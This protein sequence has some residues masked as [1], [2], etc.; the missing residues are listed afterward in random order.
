MK[1][2]FDPATGKPLHTLRE[3]KLNMA[4]RQDWIE[5]PDTFDTRAMLDFTVIGGALVE[6]GADG[7]RTWA[8][9]AVDQ[10]AGRKRL[11]FITDSPGQQA[12]YLAKEAEARAYVA[13]VSPPA[14]LADYP[15]IASEIG[16]TGA[17]ALEVANVW[18]A[19]ADQW[20]DTSAAIENARLTAKRDIA[21]AADR[22]AI[23]TA[24]DQLHDALAQIT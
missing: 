8:I 16:I 22:A 10:A 9:A 3:T 12:V 17:T 4:G 1:L 21:A 24:L 20:R 11:Q 14:D 18:I 7:L 5:V 13:L 23:R 6:T 2:V 15:M 19:M